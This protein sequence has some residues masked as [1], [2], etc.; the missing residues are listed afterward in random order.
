MSEIPAP[1]TAPASATSMERPGLGR[2]FACLAYEA[3]LLT[4]WLFIL[5][6]LWLVLLALYRHSWPGGELQIASGPELLLQRLWYLSGMAAYFVLFWV[7]GGQTLA[8]KTWR[9]R[10]VSLDGGPVRPLQALARFLVAAMAIPLFGVAW[11]WAFGSPARLW[12]HDQLS[13]TVLVRVR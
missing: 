8:M 13:K 12:L 9:I 10:L 5:G 11:L 6:V 7:R 1:A 2:Y 3:L 4:A